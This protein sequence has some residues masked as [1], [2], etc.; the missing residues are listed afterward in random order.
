MGVSVVYL[1]E[2]D[3][4]DYLVEIH[5]NRDNKINNILV[6]QKSIK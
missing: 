5:E 4:G 1:R 2:D 6:I 3:L